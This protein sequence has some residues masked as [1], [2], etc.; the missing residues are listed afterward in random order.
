M[1]ILNLK[2]LIKLLLIKTSVQMKVLILLNAMTKWTI[3]SQK[4][5]LR[6]LKQNMYM[7]K[8]LM[9]EFL[10]HRVQREEFHQIVNMQSQVQE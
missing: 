1:S 7:L 6:N 8:V 5:L 9:E 3:L 10:Q 2:L 4:V